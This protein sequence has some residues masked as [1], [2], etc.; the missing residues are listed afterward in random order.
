MWEKA[1]KSDELN[2]MG[3]RCYMHARARIGLFRTATGLYAMDN[4]CPHYEADLHMGELR[5]DHVL[6]PWHRWRFQLNTGHCTTGPNFDT[7]VYPVKEEDGF[8]WVNVEAGGPT[9]RA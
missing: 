6:C 4:T 5:E 8:I 2:P 3:T 9:P 7:N 1:C